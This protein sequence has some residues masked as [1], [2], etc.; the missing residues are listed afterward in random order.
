MTPAAYLTLTVL[1]GATVAFG[2][3][4]WRPDAV[5]VLTLLILLL[6]GVISPE[7]GFSGFGSP[8]LIAVACVFVVSAALERTGIAVLIGRRILRIAGASELRLI[9]AF[10]TVAGLLAGVMNSIGAVAVLLPAAMAAAR[11]ARIS[12]SKLLLPLAL[13]TRLG[14]NLLLISGPSNLIASEVLVHHDLRPFGLF[15]FLPLGLAFLVGGVAFLAITARRWLPDVPLQQLPHSGRLMELYRLKERL[16]EARIPEDSQLVGRTIGE[17]DL[18]RAH[19][20]T[21]LRITRGNR[22]ILAP[23]RQE[24]LFDGDLLTVQGRMEVLTKDGGLHTIGLGP[25]TEVTAPILESA[26]VRV[27]EVILAPRSTLSGKTLRDIGFREKYGVTVL[28]IWREGQPRRTAL[29]DMPVLLGDALLVQGHTERIRLLK[30]DPEFLVLEPETGEIPRVDRAVWALVSVGLMIVAI[31]ANLLPVA[32]ATLLAAGIVIAAGCLTMEEMYRA[33]DWRAL[34]MIGAMLPVAD[35]LTITGAAGAVVTSTLGWVGTESLT[36]LLV[37]LTAAI[38]T[39]QLMPSIA[40][41]AL[42]APIALQAA[43]ATGGSPFAFMMAVCAGH[44][45]T[46]TPISNPVNLLV[47]GPGGYRMR[48]YV[49]VGL[50][51]ALVL[52]AIGLIVILTFWPL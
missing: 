4:R 47:M 36:A 13:G 25:A 3:G 6:T 42:L 1:A 29:V 40:A 9:V 51:L 37:V 17:C 35:A 48:D 20:L 43:Q 45:T 22:Q 52:G 16:F 31:A 38:V 10:A 32:V 5:A 21:V 15:E 34:I 28:A 23:T 30:R 33:I 19:G 39:N 2:M 27:V 26:D 24:V 11:E 7:Q 8:V 49:R 41:T 50:P 44:G 14:G 46:F 18:G 12:P